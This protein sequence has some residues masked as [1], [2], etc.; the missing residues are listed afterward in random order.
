MPDWMRGRLS[1][2]TPTLFLCAL[3]VLLWS[4]THR[5]DVFARDGEL[6]AMQALSR[7]EPALSHDVYLSDVSQDRFT[8]F[9]PLY[10]Q[11]IRLFGIWNAGLVIFVLSTSC[12][13]ASAW[14]AV[15]R[16]CGREQAWL[17]VTTLAVIVPYYGGY[18]IFHYA[19]NFL[20]ARSVAE[21]MVAFAL[22]LH[23]SGR[24][25]SGLIVATVALVVHPLMALPGIALLLFLNVPLR[26]A[27]AGA[28]A[29]TLSVVTLALVVSKGIVVARMFTVMDR[30]WLNT[31]YERSQFL[32]LSAWRLV[33]WE[34]HAHVFICLVL[35]SLVLTDLR[36][37]RL[38]RAA[39]LV[40]FT[41]LLIA[42]ISGAIGPVAILLQGQAW[43]WFWVSGFICMLM[44]APTALALWRDGGC[45]T[46]A[47]ALLFGSWA[48]PMPHSAIVAAGSLI[49]WLI[50]GQLQGPTQALCRNG[51]LAA[52]FA[53]AVWAL[54]DSLRGV[55]IP[56][57]WSLSA[58]ADQVH[59]IFG[60]KGTALFSF[61]ALS[62][63][64]R[65]ASFKAI[66]TI[67]V[68]VL[69]VL[70]GIFGF[71]AL[72]QRSAVGT[73][74]DILAFQ[75]WIKA[76]PPTS[77]VQILPGQKSSAFIWFTLR[78]AS[79]LTVDQSSGVVFSSVTAREIVRR[80]KVLEPVMDPDW[81]VAAQIENG[82]SDAEMSHPLTR[83]RLVS[84]CRDPV[85]DFVIAEES[86]GFDSLKMTETDPWSG[87]NLY[88]CER[89][90]SIPS[91][92]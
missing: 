29:G 80:S 16:L 56:D 31:V 43:R 81:R 76:I 90:R 12:L 9:S 5:F 88:S 7:L 68:C 38:C 75:R 6:Y 83:E 34:L 40:G 67:G 71:D 10:A 74:R 64:I 17:A 50:R 49:V 26:I 62:L 2:A 39:I 61:G 24:R 47:A 11:L 92:V 79:Y 41:G 51:G 22:A 63:S 87:W 30:A 86:V 1:T 32:F 58:I 66:G 52:F 72:S 28:V 33:D 45:G 19:E 36:C 77:T 13:F 55:E 42:W 69:L 70:S 14:Y 21:A 25:T 84:I 65:S 60:V 57:T 20:T 59:T 18:F 35:S 78:R 44:L 8:L 27:V 15:L 48:L 91:R 37:R 46:L 23:I 85:L 82:K 89:V 3:A 54:V 73:P 4:L 53:M